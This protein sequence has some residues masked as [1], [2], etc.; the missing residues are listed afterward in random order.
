M[1]DKYNKKINIGDAVRCD[2]KYSFDPAEG[3]IINK[4]QVRVYKS[5]N[6]N[7]DSTLWNK[8]EGWVYFSAF[9]EGKVEKISKK[10][11]LLTKLKE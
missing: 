3:I 6:P 8:E 11:Y 10:E 4:Y 7:K 9:Q 2:W 1:I 5:L